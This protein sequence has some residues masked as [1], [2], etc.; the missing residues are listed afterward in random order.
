[1]YLVMFLL[2]YCIP[3]YSLAGVHIIALQGWQ[4]CL[5]LTSMKCFSFYMKYRDQHPSLIFILPSLSESPCLFGCMVKARRVSQPDCVISYI[6]AGLIKLEQA[7][8]AV[9][10]AQH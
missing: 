1:M 7:G 5:H 3:L 9:H 10:L 2:Y 6:T 4:V 8:A